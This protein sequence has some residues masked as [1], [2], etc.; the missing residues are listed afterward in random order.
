MR[1]DQ[2]QRAFLSLPKWTCPK[3]ESGSLVPI[4]GFL[5]D[6]ETQYSIANHTHQDFEPDWITSRFVGMLKCDIPHCG[7][8]VTVAGDRPVVLYEDYEEET[9]NWESNFQ[10]CF[11]R[12]A[13]H[14]IKVSKN[15]SD[16]CAS[17]LKK[18]FELYWVDKA[19]T[20]N[21]LRIFVEQL[22]DQFHVPTE[23]KGNKKKKHKLDLS[24]R[25][26]E[27]DQIKPGHKDALHALRIVGNF[28]SHEG[29]GETQT[30]LDCFEIL[31]DALAELVDEKK[32]KLKVKIQS[33]I[34]SKGKPDS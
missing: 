2:W 19:A 10:P 24:E 4:P 25:I 1:P 22:M 33:L 32:A 12:P 29:E 20:A 18:A 21:R 5:K 27:F 30:L 23:G 6:H 14:I 26:E 31:E 3:C 8:I 16:N 7:E 34:K 28:G 13:P 17:H 15:L 9:Q 11:I